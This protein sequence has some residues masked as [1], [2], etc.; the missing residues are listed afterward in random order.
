MARSSRDEFSDKDKQALAARAGWHCSKCGQLT[1]GPSEESTKSVTMV[2]VAAHISAAAPGPGGRRYDSSMT[3]EQRSG[4]ENGIWLC[5]TC[6]IEIDRDEV[7]YTR[8]ELRRLRLAHEQ[9]CSLAIRNRSAVNIPTGLLG[10]GTSVICTGDVVEFTKDSWT[11]NL[12]HFLEGEIATLLSL[13]E[14][15]SELPEE[16]RYI[17][18]NELG[19]GRMLSHSPSL[20]RHYDEYHLVCPILPSSQRISVEDLG[21]SLATDP[22]NNDIYVTP[23]G[24]IAMVSG[25]DYFPQRIREVLSMQIGESPFHQLFGVRLYEYYSAYHDSPWLDL[26]FKLDVIRQASIP[27]RDKINGTAETPLRCVIKV[28]EVVVLDSQPV[29]NRLSVR[30]DLEVSGI[31]RWANEVQVYMP[32][33]EQ[34]DQRKQFF[35]ESGW[36]EL[37]RQIGK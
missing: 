31:G 32:T 14:H 33:K 5:A 19:D 30:L 11:L 2:G 7:T 10:I 4:I 37:F 13:I 3:P 12:K 35:K 29:N 17:I 16:Y 6:S 21:T 28:N 15:F 34:M 9:K 22:I 25:S 23:T 1:V 24:D 27:V 36:N 18:S 8:A 26:L 20:K